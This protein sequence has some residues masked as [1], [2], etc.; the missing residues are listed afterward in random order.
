MFKRPYNPSLVGLAVVALCILAFAIGAGAFALS[1][2]NEAVSLLKVPE[3]YA[4]I[5]AAIDAAQAG[6]IIQ[7][8]SGTYNENLTLNKA[9]TLTAESFDQINPVNNTTV[10]DGMGGASAILIP[11]GM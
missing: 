4:T 11:A 6:D 8:R 2:R 10:F 9:V 1:R 5:Q 3:D 7:V